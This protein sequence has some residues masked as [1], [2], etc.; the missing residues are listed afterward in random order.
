MLFRWDGK[1]MYS[2]TTKS[3]FQA[4][5]Q[6]KGH[7]YTACCVRISLAGTFSVANAGHVA[8]DLSGR[9]VET[10]PALPLGLIANQSYELV[11]GTLAPGERLVLTVVTIALG[12]ED[13]NGADW[14][15]HSKSGGCSLIFDRGIA[16]HPR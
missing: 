7:I 10:A 9:E 6:V 15:T 1:N 4:L 5:S 12:V 8:P 11:Q 13:E 2:W 14:V 3:R 16:A